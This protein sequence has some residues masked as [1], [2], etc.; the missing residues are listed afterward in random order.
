[1]SDENQTKKTI[2]EKSEFKGN[3]VLS[4]FEIDEKG[5]KKAFPFSFGKK[6][7][8]AIIKHLE[9]IRTFAEG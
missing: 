7:A 3:P 1:M 8:Q 4:I 9:D 5:E 2:A 6:K